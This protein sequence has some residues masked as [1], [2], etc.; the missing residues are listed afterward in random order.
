MEHERKGRHKENMATCYHST[1]RR[2]RKQ[3]ET[4]NKHEYNIG[5]TRESHESLDSRL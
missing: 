2:K 3:K 4:K 1:K 5:K